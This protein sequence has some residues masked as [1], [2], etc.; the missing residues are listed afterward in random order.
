MLRNK[1]KTKHAKK[2]K[3]GAAENQPQSNQG[4]NNMEIEQWSENLGVPT[5]KESHGA[6]WDASIAQQRWANT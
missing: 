4:Q 6:N 3:A 5:G 1:K 2:S